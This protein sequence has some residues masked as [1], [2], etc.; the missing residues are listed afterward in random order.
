MKLAIGKAKKAEEALV[1]KRREVI[2]RQLQGQS[3]YSRSCASFTKTTGWY[4]TCN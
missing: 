4:S 2:F 3:F 1:I